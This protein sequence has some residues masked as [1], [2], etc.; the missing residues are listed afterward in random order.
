MFLLKLRFFLRLFF[1][2]TTLSFYLAT[3][4][5]RRNISYKFASDYCSTS[6]TWN[7]LVF[8]MKL[9]FTYC[10]KEELDITANFLPEISIGLHEIV[11]LLR[12]IS[13]LIIFYNFPTCPPRLWTSDPDMVFTDTKDPGS[14]YNQ[15]FQQEGNS[16][17]Y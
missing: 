13:A 9:R 5:T 1:F 10:N 2:N 17:K 12:N 16:R 11:F 8:R 4:I 7:L 6:F 14:L 15:G 3:L